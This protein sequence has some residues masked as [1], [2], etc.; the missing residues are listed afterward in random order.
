MIRKGLKQ[1][2]CLLW[3]QYLTL[4]IRAGCIDPKDEI[5]PLMEEAHWILHFLLKFDLLSA[6]K[7]PNINSHP[8]SRQ[9]RMQA[10]QS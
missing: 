10:T 8:S 2:V 1:Q 7:F 5:S 9:T 6:D 4:L 3:N